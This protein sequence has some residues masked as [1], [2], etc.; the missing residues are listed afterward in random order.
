M[1]PELIVTAHHEPLYQEKFLE[2]RQFLV[3]CS[4][5]PEDV[6]YHREVDIL[7]SRGVSSWRVHL[8]LEG[9]VSTING[10]S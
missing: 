7:P 3:G 4:S 1:S 6:P 8:S 9:L 10:T 2:L 5:T